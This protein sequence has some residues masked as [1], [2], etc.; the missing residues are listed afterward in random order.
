MS[1]GNGS[2]F[3]GID[4]GGTKTDAVLTD[5]AGVILARAK[6][7]GLSYRHNGLARVLEVLSALLEACSAEASLSPGDIASICVGLPLFGEDEACDAMLREKIGEALGARVTIVNDVEAA[8]AGARSLLPGLVVVSGTG[9]IAFGRDE[10]G[11]AARA[12]GW[13]EHFSDEGSAYWLAIRGMGVFSKQ[14]DGRLPRGPLYELVR[15]TFALRKDYE[16]IRVAEEELLPSREKTAEFQLLMAQ[17]ARRGDATMPPLYEE[18]AKELSRALVAVK[19]G[20]DFRADPV[21]ASYA[22][23][24]FKVGGMVIDPLRA[25]LSRYGI[26]LEPPRSTPAEGAALIASR[27]VSPP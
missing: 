24:V 13:S 11:G 17:A 18:A 4:G 8:W 12:G 27:E 7:G 20:L 3:L 25:E 23:G 16:F 19:E 5:A 15:E 26:R 22:G 9:M 1:G 10:K 14:S 2:Y 21:I 6:E